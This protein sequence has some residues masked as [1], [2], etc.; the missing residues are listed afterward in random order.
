[1]NIYLTKEQTKV[2]KEILKQE[3]FVNKQSTWEVNGRR[4][5]NVVGQLLTKV[6]GKGGQ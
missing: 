5:F 6:V 3:L 1:M 4:N 2:L